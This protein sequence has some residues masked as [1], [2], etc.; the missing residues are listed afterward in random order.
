MSRTA[1][2][3]GASPLVHLDRLQLALV[4]DPRG[5]L[6]PVDFDALPFVPRRLF[7]VRDVPV[8]QVRGGHAH[9]SAWQLLLCLGGRIRVEARR[10]GGHDEVLLD[11]AGS[12]LLVEPGT[13]TAQTYLDPESALLVLASERYDPASYRDH[14]D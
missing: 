9:R 13:W 6:L 11:R 3:G 2:P 12:G 8:G 5:A 4:T 10:E 1:P 7:V 14:V